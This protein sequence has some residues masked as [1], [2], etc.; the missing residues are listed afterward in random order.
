MRYLFFIS[1]LLI[2]KWGMAAPASEMFFRKQA[3][4]QRYMV[5]AAHP[6]AVRA[7]ADVLE[8]DGNA[9]DAALVAQFVLNVVEPQGSGIGGGGFLLY[10]DA[11]TGKTHAYDG[12]ETAPKLTPKTI[13]TDQDG[14]P[15]PLKQAVP[16]GRSVGAPGLLAMLELVHEEHGSVDW[17]ELF[18][19]AIEI[20]R[21]GYRYSEYQ[22]EMA[23]WA[24]H[25]LRQPDFRFRF[26]KPAGT[27]MRHP[28][29]AETFNQLSLR[30]S[31]Y[32]YH[33]ELGEKVVEAV[34]RA[35]PPGYLTREDLMAY[36]AYK[37]P[38]LCGSYRQYRICGMGPPSSGAIAVLQVM[39]MLEHFSLAH[40]EPYSAGS[41]HLIVEA[42]KLAYADRNQYVADTAYVSVP[43][44]A[45][46]DWDYLQARAALIDPAKAM[47]VAMPGLADH[48][49]ESTTHLSIIDAKGNAVA[50]TSSIEHPFGSGVMAGGFLLNNELTDFS[51]VAQKDGKPV[52][53]RI[54]GGKRPRSSMSP[55][56]VFNPDGSLKM[57]LGSPGG[58]RIIPYVIETLIAVLDW[59][60]PLAEAI[61]RPHVMNRGGVTELEGER[62]PELNMLEDALLAKGHDVG[63]ARMIS[64]L[65]A[66]EIKE[67]G[68][69]TGAADPRRDGV[70]FGR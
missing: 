60:I 45:L 68:R 52:A 41:W 65:H 32:F 36:Q 6:E 17:V 59:N 11:T 53:N 42:E 48:E 64:G 29:L 35:E 3:E 38:P 8:R 61:A 31:F 34:R 63:Y 24:V 25:L 18:N 2:A 66:I 15:V 49:S 4:G 9:I 39:G 7:A 37:Q 43:V 55:T 46:L 10:Y 27:L 5:S 44:G 21:R 16:G 57:V 69:L 13:F 19:P 51:F 40:R 50:L 28:A 30:G 67:N 33:G 14:Q 12:R 62:G 56:L 54:E 47:E 20:A 58:S 22:E 1:V 23:K 70:A 26:R